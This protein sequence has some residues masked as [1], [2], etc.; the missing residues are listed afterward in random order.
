M[1][2][3]VGLFLILTGLQL[4]AIDFFR[5]PPTKVVTTKEQ[6]LYYHNNIHEQNYYGSNSWAVKFDLTTLYPQVGTLNFTAEAA[7][8]Y[9]PVADSFDDV[10]VKLCTDQAGQPAQVLQS[11][12]ISPQFGWNQLEFSPVT[13]SLFWLVL[14][15][16]TNYSNQYIAAS[17]VDGQHSYFWDE[18]YGSDGYYRN[19]GE[20]GFNSELMVNLIGEF[21]ID[22]IELELAEFQFLKNENDE[23]YPWLKIL[24]NSNMQADFVYLKLNITSPVTTLKDSLVLEPILAEASL[25]FDGS[26]N[27]A[28]YQLEEEPSEYE[29]TARVGTIG[30]L[31]TDN[32]VQE[33][34]FNN[35][36]LEFPTKVVENAVNISGWSQE[37]W[38]V[39]SELQ[40]PEIYKINYFADADDLPFYNQAALQRFN[41]YD[42]TGFPVTIVNGEKRIVGFNPTIYPDSLQ[43]LLQQP[44]PTTFIQENNFTAGYLDNVEE[45][46]IDIELE[47]PGAHVFNTTL[48]NT[49]LWIGVAQDSV[50][51][52]ID[53]SG[54]VLIEILYQKNFP[55]LTYGQTETDTLTVNKTLDIS[56]IN[57]DY[58]NCTL[59]YWVQNS[60][61]KQIYAFNSIP[62]TDI[63]V[64]SNSSGIVPKPEKWQIYP[65]PFSYESGLQIRTSLKMKS[66]KF[67]IYNIKGQLI[68]QLTATERW[69]G[70]DKSGRKVAPGV[71]FIRSIKSNTVKRCILLK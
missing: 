45:I 68:K 17:A 44:N 11:Y 59:I 4:A 9:C 52:D 67:N 63:E 3:I 13:D 61:T 60:S 20:L 1:R 58:A 33:I 40:Q 24:N 34:N 42:L 65:N 25:I 16:P 46:F 29:I 43:T 70:Y 8:F 5:V 19:M 2:K 64:V 49:D 51:Q 57:D 66:N 39:L 26:E 36:T 38:D 56:A 21:Q 53:I 55:T 48:L 28:V 30:E 71:Y 10:T 18:N 47:N 62:F 22:G 27:S 12:T 54:S 37:I 6:Q 35:F 15:Y 23:Y 7:K 31:I 41:Y 14:D 32:N 69:F 50:S